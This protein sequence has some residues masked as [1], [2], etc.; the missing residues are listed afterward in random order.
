L[1]F[2]VKG[3]TGH[4]SDEEIRRI[5]NELV[6]STFKRSFYTSWKFGELALKS[7]EE[8]IIHASPTPYS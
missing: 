2:S 6:V 5:M 3:E 7:L 1:N 8:K 4:K